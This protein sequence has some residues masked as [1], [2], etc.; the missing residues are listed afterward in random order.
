MMNHS[1]LIPTIKVGCVFQLQKF[2]V[3][4]VVCTT[5]RFHNIVLDGGLDLLASYGVE[6]FT[7]CNLGSGTGNER[8]DDTGLLLFVT[9]S[10]TVVE[11][12]TGYSSGI[13]YDYPVL[14]WWRRK[15]EFA[16]G[17]IDAGLSEIGLSLSS[18]S[19]YLNRHRI[20]NPAGLYT[21]LDVCSDEG[22]VVWADLYLF[23][24][25]DVEE[26]INKGFFFNSLS[27]ETYIPY[28]W[29]T[30]S[31]WLTADA[32]VPGRIEKEDVRLTKTNTSVYGA[33]VPA[34]EI[35]GSYTTGS[36]Y[37]DVYAIWDPGDLDGDYV[38]LLIQNGDATYSRIDFETPITMD[39]LANPFT[40]LR[41]RIRRDWGRTLQ[42]GE[43]L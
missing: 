26:E 5:P 25:A 38:G 12:S 8:T 28:T 15:F 40:G 20:V 30:L 19:N 32:F 34:R 37:K 9:S 23:G 29:K 17:S 14:R 1:I 33:G 11:S 27:G 10:D 4:G 39:A 36:F 22:L 24:V 43:W 35:I 7:C 18:D 41:L 2:N 31:G 13:G 6:D 42:E 16:I 3:D 21:G